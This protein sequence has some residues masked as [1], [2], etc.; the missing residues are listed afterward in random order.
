[1]VL[2]PTTVTD[3]QIAGVIKYLER[4]TGATKNPTGSLADYFRSRTDLVTPKFDA[5]DFSG[6]TTLSYTWTSCSSLTSFPQ[7]DTSSVTSFST[8]WYGLQLLTSFPKLD[9]SS[10]TNFF[11]TWSSCRGLTSFPLMDFSSAT[12]LY[13]SWHNCSGLTS[14]SLL[15][16]SS[17]TNFTNT[18]RG[19]TALESFPALDLSSGTNFSSTWRDC[20][21]LASF[22]LLDVSSG[23][24]FSY[25][26]RGCSALTSF[27]LLDV[28]SGT[29][30]ASCWVSCTALTSFPLLDTSSSTTFADSWNSCAA[31][32]TFSA[33]FFDDWNPASISSACF[34]NTWANCT[35][36]TEQSVENILLSISASGQWATDDGTSSGTPLAS[37]YITIDSNNVDV[38]NLTAATRAASNALQSRGWNVVINGSIVNEY[39]I[40]FNGSDEY[41]E[42]AL[43]TVFDDI[44]SNDFS[45]SL[46]FKHDGLSGSQRLFEA[47]YDT[48]NFAQLVRTDGQVHQLVVNKGGSPIR[49]CDRQRTERGSV[50]S[51]RRGLGCQ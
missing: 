14:F 19:C 26:W 15:D 47:A 17:G 38:N 30:F 7:I 23:T 48:N 41:V 5:L 29:N 37:N 9:T 24:A 13:S 34:D 22:P 2:L 21:S 49:H 33:G 44:A 12:N 36:L 6:V 31:L 46:W 28:S 27:P 50:V 40:N 45:V 20:T 10:A 11:Q 8:A 39:S 1:M 18:W 35:A 51:P 4:E 42:M 16:L 32:T 43:S 3:T 25:A